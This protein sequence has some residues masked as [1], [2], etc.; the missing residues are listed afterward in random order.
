M[1]WMFLPSTCEGLIDRFRFCGQCV[2][3]RHVGHVRCVRSPR[4]ASR[5]MRRLAFACNDALHLRAAVFG[6]D[7]SFL[8]RCVRFA[9]STACFLRYDAQ[10]KKTTKRDFARRMDSLASHS[11]PE[12]I[13]CRV[14]FPI[15]RWSFPA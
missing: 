9:A 8:A 15:L 7:T 2:V 5:A 14:S 3:M 12:V 1:V 13:A 6:E 4:S 11:A 10:R